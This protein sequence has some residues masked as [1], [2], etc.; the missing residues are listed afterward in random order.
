MIFS[1]VKFISLLWYIYLFP[2]T[3]KPTHL[4]NNPA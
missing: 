4:N 1:S 3:F 2:E